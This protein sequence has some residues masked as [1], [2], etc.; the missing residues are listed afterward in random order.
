M[1]PEKLNNL[2]D[3]VSKP[4]RY[5][6]GE[7]GE[8]IKDKEG[9]C[10]VAFCFPDN[11]EIGMSN[12]G[13]KILYGVLNEL[14]FVRC[15]RCFAPMPDMAELMKTNG[16]PLYALESADP[17]KSFD[18]VAFT[19][20]YE[21][22]Y[23]NILYM[24]ELADIEFYADK[25]PDLPLGEAPILLCGG[26]CTYNPEPFADFFDIMSIGEGEEALP[27]LMELYRKCKDDGMK[28]IEFLRLA[29]HLSGFYVPS[30]YKV[31]Y[32]TDGTI[33]KFAPLFP[34]VPARI[35]KRHVKDFENAYFPVKQVVPFT[36]AVHDRITLEVFRGCIR[37][38]RFCQAGMVCRPIRERSAQKLND[39]AKEVFKNTGYDEISACCLSI[40]DYSQLEEFCDGLLSWC[41]AKSVNI[42]LPSMRIDS[43]SKELLEKSDSLR[44]TSLTFAPE[45]G[46]QALRDRINKGVT[47]EDL[48]RSVGYAF[49]SGHTS[50][51]LYFMDGLPTET[52]EDVI[53]IADLAQKCVNVY[54]K[55]ES[56]PKGR[57]VNV[58]ISVSCFVPKP[59]TP[60]QWDGQNMPDELMRKQKL[61]RENVRTKKISYAYHD[62]RVSRIEAF[63]ARGNRKL[64]K[65]IEA[66]YRNGQVFDA[67]DEY[68]IYDKWLSAAEEAGVDVAFFANRTFSRDEI[69]PWDFLDIG[70]SK[71]HLKR[72]REKADRSEIT[73][74][75]IYN[76]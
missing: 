50:V 15:E 9:K 13:I 2:L 41:G 30:L 27:E 22:C 17:V 12:L 48:M 34:D 35:K 18:I 45:A 62:A 26:P 74:G 32:N 60:F 36:E 42:S 37:G 25:R 54:Y 19:L 6:G 63:F 76:K 66:A 65:V 16:V 69:L 55:S 28:K 51:K 3:S 5:I 29:S 75:K 40:S 72:E 7:Y 67:W 4:S 14:D 61:I 1:I 64:S 56:K 53:G 68:F 20:Q 46:T 33:S 58:N 43:F 57:G 31:D 73:I 44:K 71:A 24:L 11:Y 49:D 38:C 8:I 52:D 10:S 21:M 70:I 59:F 39:I 23:T 47:E